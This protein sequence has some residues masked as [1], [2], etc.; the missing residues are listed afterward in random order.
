MKANRRAERGKK[1]LFPSRNHSAGNENRW[2]TKKE[3]GKKSR[4]AR[5]LVLSQDKGRSQQRT[6]K[7]RDTRQ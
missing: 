3:G 4:P 2:K 7:F 1:T 6:E 5:V